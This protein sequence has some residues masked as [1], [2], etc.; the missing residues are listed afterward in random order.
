M[1]Q[2]KGCIKKD[3]VIN[4]FAE[5]LNIPKDGH[6]KEYI[7]RKEALRQIFLEAM[8]HNFDFNAEYME[9]FMSAKRAIR[10]TPAANVVEVRYGQ[11][12]VHEGHEDEYYEYCSE[13]KTTD[14]H[15]GDNFCPKCGC[16]LVGV[17]HSKNKE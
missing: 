2:N 14:I 10:N 15:S 17:K 16:K 12:I 9:I 4:F 5:R 8:G 11:V 7:E 1:P 6:M 3:S 13:C